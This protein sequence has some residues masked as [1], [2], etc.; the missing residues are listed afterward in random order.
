M[1]ISYTVVLKC[2]HQFRGLVGLHVLTGM[3]IITD[4]ISFKTA[5]MFQI[6]VVTIKTATFGNVEGTHSLPSPSPIG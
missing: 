6:G 5:R 4:S 3:Y 2:Y 1:K